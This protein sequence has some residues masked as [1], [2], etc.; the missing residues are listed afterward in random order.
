MLYIIFAI[1]TIFI[2]WAIG[3]YTS[4]L[5]KKS[6]KHR[7]LVF[8]A[9]CLVIFF[10]DGAALLS[11]SAACMKAGVHIEKKIP[12]TGFYAPTAD[13]LFAQRYLRR[14]YS[15]VET[16][17]LGSPIIRHTRQGSTTAR[18]IISGYQ[19]NS[20]DFKLWYK[21]EINKATIVR[22]ANG[23]VVGYDS[24]ASTKGGF[25]LQAIKQYVF[26]DNTYISCSG[27]TIGAGPTGDLIPAVLP[28]LK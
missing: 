14:G 18:D 12:S 6:T 16:G 10:D 17:G 23:E 25:I 11:Y 8:L 22:I 15:Y 2:L 9:F 5:R 1:V 19:V 20:G 28:P 7:V 24:I 27:S 26:L 4:S 21:T 13:L 3:K